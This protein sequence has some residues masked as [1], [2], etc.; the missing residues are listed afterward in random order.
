MLRPVRVEGAPEGAEAPGDGLT[1]APAVLHGPV[2]PVLSALRFLFAAGDDAWGEPPD[3]PGVGERR[4]HADAAVLLCRTV[5]SLRSDE[6]EARALLALLLLR[7]A[8]RDARADGAPRTLAEQDRSLWRQDEIAEGR[9]VLEGALAAGR[10]GPYLVAAAIEA[11]HDEAPTAADTE[12]D[13]IL[14]LYDVLAGM[15]PSPRV[16][17]ERAVARGMA[18]G[19]QVGLV[20]LDELTGSAGL[21]AQLAAARAELLRAG[22][23]ETPR[24]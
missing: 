14:A 11:M 22:P 10:P 1:P 23:G 2:G 3:A 18:H 5:A 9:R 16:A 12:W 6:P 8:R 4:A 13:E 24:V 21:D 15:T 19:V 17:L 7:H 20:A